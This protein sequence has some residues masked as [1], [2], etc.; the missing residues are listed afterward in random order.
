MTPTTTE[1]SNPDPNTR[2]RPRSGSSSRRFRGVAC[3]SRVRIWRA[4]AGDL[5]QLRRLRARGVDAGLQP[6][7]AEIDS[8]RARGLGNS[9]A[10]FAAPARATPSPMNPVPSAYCPPI[11]TARSPIDDAAGGQRAED[12]PGRAVDEDRVGPVEHAPAAARCCRAQKRRSPG[13][14]RSRTDP[15]TPAYPTLPFGGAEIDRGRLRDHRRGAPA[16]S[17]LPANAPGCPWYSY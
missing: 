8:G 5:A 15:A 17:R 11:V 2:P 16:S 7:R 3:A 12:R 9:R 10:K 14:S 4:G 13:R 6:D 1:I